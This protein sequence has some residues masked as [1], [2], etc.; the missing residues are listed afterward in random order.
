MR[1]LH[2]VGRPVEALDW[3]TTTRKRLAEDLGVV[4]STELQE[5]HQAILR[6][7][8]ASGRG[9][10]RWQWPGGPSDIHDPGVDPDLPERPRPAELLVP[11]VCGCTNLSSLVRR[12][13]A[14]GWLISVRM[15]KACRQA[16][17]APVGSPAAP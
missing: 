6:G 15:F 8:P 4:A 11:A 5:L 2:A 17:C 9:K 16:V 10:R 7:E 12:P 14:S 3:Y 1:T 13:W